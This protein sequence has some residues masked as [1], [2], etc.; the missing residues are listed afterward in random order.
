MRERGT[1]RSRRGISHVG[2]G[3]LM[4]AGL[5]IAIIV[6]AISARNEKNTVYL[7]R[8]GWYEG[9]GIIYL[10]T[11]K[12][13][14]LRFAKC[15]AEKD[16]DGVL[17]LWM[18][19]EIIEVKEGTRARV[20]DDSGMFHSKVRILTGKHKGAVGWTPDVFIH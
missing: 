4:A 12:G 3:L 10:G 15:N 16:E 14:L 6:N 20:L 17:E 19:K 8:P 7:S 11:S 1:F 13:A 2:I 9:G 5:A 18:L